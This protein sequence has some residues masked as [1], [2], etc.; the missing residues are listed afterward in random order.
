MN[1]IWRYILT[2]IF[3]TIGYLVY[4]HLQIA[5]VWK[6]TFACVYGEIMMGVNFILMDLKDR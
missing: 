2:I 3:T 5:D 4:H 6:Y 1:K